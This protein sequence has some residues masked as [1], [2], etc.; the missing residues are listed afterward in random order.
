MPVCSSSPKHQQRQRTSESEPAQL[1]NSGSTASGQQKRLKRS[2]SEPALHYNL[3]FNEQRRKRNAQTEAA[4]H[5]NYINTIDALPDDLLICI[6]VALSSTATS[7]SDLF[8]TMLV[9]KR[10]YAAGTNPHVL[11]NAGISALAVKASAWSK[12]AERFFKQCVAAG[13]AEAC[14]IL[15]MIWEL[16]AINESKAFQTRKKLM[17]KNLSR[18][19]ALLDNDVYRGN[20]ISAATILFQRQCLEMDEAVKALRKE[21]Q[22]H[23]L[24]LL[25]QKSI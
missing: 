4:Q 20:Q 18:L 6:M 16:Q 23:I 22:E 19:Q 25:R 15:S 24:Q 21:I 1:G 11:A 13:N 3:R 9:S 17:K 5:V 8:N 10:F 12:G 2:P 14:R 7:P